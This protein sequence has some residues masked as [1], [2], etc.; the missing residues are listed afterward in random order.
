M[1]L[2]VKLSLL[3]LLVL[4]ILL[5][6]TI[7]L[8]T[9]NTRTLTQEVGSERIG[10]EVTTV[11]SQLTQLEREL[12]VHINFLVSSVTFFQAVG[13]R[14][15]AAVND[16][17]SRLN[18]SPEFYDIAVVD[19]DGHRL[20]DTQVDADHDAEDALLA[21]ARAKTESDTIL[22][23]QNEGQVQVSIVAAAPIVS[24][25]G[26]V[27]GAIQISRQ[28]D[29]VFLSDLTFNSG[30]VYVGLVY[31]DQIIARNTDTTNLSGLNQML[32]PDVRFDAP[33]VQ[34]AQSGQIV[35]SNKLVT[36]R[37]TPYAAAYIPVVRTGSESSA[38]LMVLVELSEITSF[39]NTTLLNTIVVFVVL[40]FLT[41]AFIYFTLYRI[42]IRP[43][44]TVRT[45]AQKMIGGQY[46]QRIP[47][48]TRDELGQLA[49]T[50]NEM[51]S[52][53]QQREISLHHAREEA[54]RS[55]R[56]KSAFLASMSHELRTP[57]NSIINFT[58]FV[59]EGDTGPI[60]QEQ[61]DL[62]SEVVTGSRHLLNLINDVLDMSKIEAGSL[63]LFIEDNINLNMILSRVTATGRSL[64]ANRPVTITLEAEDNLPPTRGDQQRILQI[65]LNIMSN[66]CKFTEEGEIKVRA[67]HI[68]DEIV[69]TFSDTGPGI[70]VEERDLIFQVFMQTQ[71]GIKKGGGTGL[72]MPIAKSLA[73]AHGGRLWFESELGKGTSFYVALPMKSD[74]LVPTLEI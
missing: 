17:I 26:N 1:G 51:A 50:F 9:F 25:T 37:N 48:T 3:L 39:Q 49:S 13:S 54:E 11:R 33:S 10:Q 8:L 71:S 12:Q 28:I 43:I 56:V 22:V 18:L 67:R 41:V 74:L 72:G 69:I 62:L 55:D 65:F 57:L 42:A 52:A 34:L 63:R 21:T 2:A 58:S 59:L 15:A 45:I 35:V 16:I 38:I 32:V 40:A 31:N 23:E 7:L 66:A 30:Q 4:S 70:P 27:L 61:T 60:T 5:L 73:E 6:S 44:D 14:D 68:K 24:V 36:G 29:S 53:V 19:G 47:L 46:D 64:L 20:I